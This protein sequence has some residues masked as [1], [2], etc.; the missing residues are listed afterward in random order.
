MKHFRVAAATL[1]LV[2]AVLQAPP[3]R[4]QDVSYETLTKVEVPGAL[5]TMMKAA[6]KLGGGSLDMVQKTYIKGNRM[7]TD[8]DKSSTI[9]DLDGRRFITLDHNAK[10]YTAMTFEQMAAQA[11]RAA[12]Q[13]QNERTRAG[14]RATEK[15]GQTDLKFRF[16]TDAADQSETIAGYDANRYFLTMEM[17]GEYT[18]EGATEK[19][20]GGTLV[21]LTDMWAAR[22][23]PT[24]KALSAFRAASAQEWAGAESAITKAIATA[25][26]DQPGVDVAFEQSVKEAR[27][28]E[29]TPLRTVVHFVAVAPDQKFDR[30]LTTAEKPR[31]GGV[32][33]A[34]GKGMLGGLAGRLG[35]KQE[36]QPATE[37]EQP[38]QATILRVSTETRNISTKAVD[39]KVFEIPA[40]YKEVKLEELMK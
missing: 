26:A 10:T 38:T 15:S 5:G 2:P 20:K 36:E 33:K 1:W 22:D 11:Q 4:A 18:P 31:S 16:K 17:E 29:G 32:L 25:F 19:E 27:K 7:R 3:V 24:M 6:A 8:M 28:I 30:E 35:K 9:M 34:A 23:V 12:E 39:P 40:G 13:L 37:A 14:T 21:L